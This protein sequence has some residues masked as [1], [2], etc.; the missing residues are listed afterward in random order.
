MNDRRIRGGE[1]EVVRKNDGRRQT[2]EEEERKD[3]WS[4][5]KRERVQKAQTL[6][7]LLTRGSLTSSKPDTNHD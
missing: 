2:E 6:K 7:T 4:E 1:E 5:K 3:G